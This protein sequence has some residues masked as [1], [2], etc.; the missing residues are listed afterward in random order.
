MPPRGLKGVQMFLEMSESFFNKV[1]GGFKRN[2]PTAGVFDQHIG[3]FPRLLLT[4]GVCE[5]HI[6]VFPR[7][8]PITGVYEQH[9]GGC[10]R[11]LLIAGVCQL[12]TS[13]RLTVLTF[14]P[15]PFN[16]FCEK[17]ITICNRLLSP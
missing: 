8:L 11:H 10:L 6:G 14:R 16:I 12:H 17:P 1:W 9:I 15:C 5:D 13:L 7:P 4:T 3:V 2:M